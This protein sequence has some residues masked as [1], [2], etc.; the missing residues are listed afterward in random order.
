MVTTTKEVEA[1]AEATKKT[2]KLYHQQRL[3]PQTAAEQQK[4]MT[5]TGY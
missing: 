1:K 5:M 2:I 3:R 4:Q